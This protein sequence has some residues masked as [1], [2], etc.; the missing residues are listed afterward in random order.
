ME[1]ASEHREQWHF[2][3][4]VFIRRDRI[5]NFGVKSFPDFVFFVKS[6]DSAIRSHILQGNTNIYPVGIERILE[7]SL[8]YVISQGIRFPL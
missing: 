4:T 8:I 7:I 5:H 2:G 3:K 1:E 6:Q